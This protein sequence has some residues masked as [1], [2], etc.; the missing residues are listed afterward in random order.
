M[1]C[2]WTNGFWD[3]GNNNIRRLLWFYFF[4]VLLFSR[5]LILDISTLCKVWLC[6]SKTEIKTNSPPTK[7]L[8]L[9]A[10]QTAQTCRWV[11]SCRLQTINLKYCLK[12]KC[13]FTLCPLI[14][15]SIEQ[16]YMF[17][18]PQWLHYDCAAV[19]LSPPDEDGERCLG[20]VSQRGSGPPWRGEDLPLCQTGVLDRWEWGWFTYKLA[21]LLEW[22]VSCLSTHVWVLLY[23]SALCHICVDELS[24]VNVTCRNMIPI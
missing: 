15:Q 8:C 13:L 20:A 23:K 14:C 9:L 7:P 3:I 24:V 1:I 17:E 5:H 22:I 16:S 10:Q 4:I 18:I 2:K 11:W 21:E 6:M 12:N 19:W